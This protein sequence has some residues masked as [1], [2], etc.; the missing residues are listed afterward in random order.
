MPEEIKCA[1]LH[2]QRQW[3]HT[4]VSDIV[5]TTIMA[6]FEKIAD[7]R[8][9]DTDCPMVLRCKYHNCCMHIKDE[10]LETKRQT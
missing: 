5:D 10:L 9:A 8:R 4:R 7:L 6:D 3:L 2:Q 1:S